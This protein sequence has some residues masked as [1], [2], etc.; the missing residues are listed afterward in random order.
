MNTCLIGAIGARAV[1][2][3]FGPAGIDLPHLARVQLN[4]NSFAEDVM[5]ELEAAFHG[6]LGEMDDNDSDG[7][8]DDDLSSDEEEDEEDEGEAP[9][10]PE[11]DDL[12]DAMSKSQIV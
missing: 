3:A 11:V 7:E 1:I 9:A 10:S 2:D 6:K 5:G 8:A 12:A 4:G